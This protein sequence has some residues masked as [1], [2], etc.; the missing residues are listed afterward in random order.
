MFLLWAVSFDFCAWI[1]I[2]QQ[3]LE[4]ALADGWG[5]FGVGTPIWEPRPY[6]TRGDIHAGAARPGMQPPIRTASR[7]MIRMMDGPVMAAR[8][9]RTE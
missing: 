9:R 3:K 1:I 7:D 2:V 4:I 5:V 8:I 6:S